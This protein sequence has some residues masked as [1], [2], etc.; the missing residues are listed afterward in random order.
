MLEMV[1]SCRESQKVKISQMGK[2][3]VEFLTTEIDSIS[4]NS[5]SKYKPPSSVVIF[6]LI[7]AH[8]IFKWG[9]DTIS[10]LFLAQ[11]KQMCSN[12][13]FRSTV[14]FVSFC[15]LLRGMGR[16][17]QCGFILILAHLS[18]ESRDYCRGK[19][20]NCFVSSSFP[21]FSLLCVKMH[22]VIYSI[23]LQA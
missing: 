6:F 3:T 17:W 20:R 1:Y 2:E 19:E 12:Q 4:H 16:V 5:N 14:S 7:F 22:Q 10:I 15:L 23:C 11:C 13:M 21:L 8:S 18:Q 9:V